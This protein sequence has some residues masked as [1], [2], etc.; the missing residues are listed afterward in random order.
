MLINKPKILLCSSDSSDKDIV[1][2]IL[3][4]HIGQ[5]FFSLQLKCLITLH[6]HYMS[7][8]RRFYPKQLTINVF[9]HEYKLRTTRIKKVTFL[10]ESQTT[11]VP[12][13]SAI[14]VPLKCWS[15]FIHDIVR[16]DVPLVPG[17][18]CGDFLL[19]SVGSSFHHWWSKD[20]KQSGFFRVHD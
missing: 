7:F 14:Q 9:N 6:Y 4:L 19:M 2:S 17:G 20:S 3:S 5:L 8:S 13:V 1:M 18:R 15:V 10:K 12:E 16:K 11:K